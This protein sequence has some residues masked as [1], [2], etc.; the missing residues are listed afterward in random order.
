MIAYQNTRFTKT[1]NAEFVPGAD[2]DEEGMALVWVMWQGQSRVQP[3]TGAADE[4]F[5]GFALSRATPPGFLVKVQEGVVPDAG[6][7][8]GKVQLDREP[9]QAQLF[10]RVGSTDITVNVGTGVPGTAGEANLDG[11][12]LTFHPDQEGGQFFAQFHYEPSLSEAKHITGDTPIGGNPAVE[13]GRVGLIYDGNPIVIS[14]FD[15]SV[16]WTGVMHPT[17]GANGLLTVGG[18]GTELTGY[19]IKQSPSAASPYLTLQS[20][21]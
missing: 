20:V 1:A 18:S 5:A 13:R 15:A 11:Q 6:A 14:N 9:D 12:T 4:V 7:M 2:I 8:K 16:D 10:V 17:L 3:S 19:V 21:G